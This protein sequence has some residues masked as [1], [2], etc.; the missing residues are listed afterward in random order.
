M[1]V[2]VYMYIICV[3]V[4]TYICMWMKVYSTYMYIHLS[5]SLS[6]S[7][8]LSGLRSL[9]GPIQ[10]PLTTTACLY[11]TLPKC[12]GPSRTIA[13]L[14]VQESY[15]GPLL[16][17]PLILVG[18]VLWAVVLYMVWGP[19]EGPIEGAHRKFLSY[20]QCAAWPETVPLEGFVKLRCFFEVSP[21]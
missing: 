7:P 18:S 11:N 13:I 10:N 19:D 15:Y 8:P 4:S 5:L 2:Y 17:A 16:W 9:W 3:Y 12:P 20:G 14:D 1:C 6:V 21:G